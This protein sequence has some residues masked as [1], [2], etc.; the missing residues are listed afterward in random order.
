[1]VLEGSAAVDL[2]NTYSEER[3]PIGWLRHQQTFARPNYRRWAGMRSPT[4]RCTARR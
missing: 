3:Q 4:S 1:M 2:L